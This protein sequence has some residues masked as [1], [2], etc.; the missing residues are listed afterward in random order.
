MTTA[1]PRS[2]HDLPAE[3]EERA[4]AAPTCVY[5]RHHDVAGEDLT[6]GSWVDL[7]GQYGAR[8]ITGLSFDPA[9]SRRRMTYV[10][11]NGTEDSVG[12]APDDFY[13]LV[14]PDSVAEI[15]PYASADP[16]TY[17]DLDPF[18]DVDG[19][20]VSY[21]GDDG[22]MIVLGHPGRLRALNAVYKLL[23]RDLGRDEA[24]VDLGR[25]CLVYGWAYKM[26]RCAEFPDCTNLACPECQDGSRRT[27][28]SGCPMGICRDCEEIKAQAWCLE[29]SRYPDNRPDAFP[30]VIVYA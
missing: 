29:Y 5:R 15:N 6:V 28:H 18:D 21:V 17:P 24:D 25:R 2:L 27:D 3:V 30:V 10:L 14:D 26:E 1:T 8:Q 11:R 22:D 12:I 16:T 9:T 23:V 4:V 13:T 20:R 19:V 7:P